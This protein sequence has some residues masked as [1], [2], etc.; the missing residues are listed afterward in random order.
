MWMREREPEWH[1]PD[2]GRGSSA[3]GDPLCEAE[4]NDS[5]DRGHGA[6]EPHMPSPR[7]TTHPSHFSMV[8]QVSLPSSKT[9]GQQILLSAA[10][11]WL[12]GLVLRKQHAL[13]ELAGCDLPPHTGLLLS[14]EQ[15]TG[16]EGSEQHQ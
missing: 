7:N 4:Q 10:K 5:D 16:T 8:V 15:T 3:A 14:M 13:L 6:T 2:Q 12:H 1:Q 11:R 9:S